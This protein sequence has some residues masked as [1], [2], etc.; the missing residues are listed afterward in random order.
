[1]ILYRLQV[2]NGEEWTNEWA[3]TQSAGKKAFDQAVENLPDNE[4]HLDEMDV[5]TNKVDGR[6]GRENVALALTRAHVNRS[7]WPGKPLKS[8]TPATKNAAVAALLS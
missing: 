8:H 4:I 6:S 5:P 1:M 2:N 3:A 7:V